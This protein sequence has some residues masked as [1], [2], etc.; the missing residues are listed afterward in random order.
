MDDAQVVTEVAE[1][2][3][4]GV[5]DAPQ[6]AERPSPP[7][8]ETV[9]D[10]GA[11]DRRDSIRQARETSAKA[12]E[13]RE[14]KAA[15]RAEPAKDRPEGRVRA[16]DGKFA[17]DKAPEAQVTAPSA[18]AVE[19]PK[20]AFP[21]AWASGTRKALYDAASPELRAELAGREQEQQAGVDK[22]RQETQRHT[23]IATEFDRVT[24]PYMATMR[25]MNLNPISVYQDF[26]NTA[27]ILNTG[28]PDQK[29]K[30][31]RD[32]AQ[33]YGVDLGSMQ[34][35]PGAYQ[36]PTITAFDR[37]LEAI[38]QGHLQRTQS[39]AHARMSDAERAVDAFAKETDPAGVPL[40]P[41]IETVAEDMMDRLPRLR[42]KNPGKPHGEILQMAY[43]AAVWGNA[44][45]RKETLAA[46]TKAQEDKRASDERERIARARHAAGSITGGPGVATSTPAQ[47]GKSRR[48]LISEGMS[49]HRV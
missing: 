8:H 47:Q 14:A 7:K 33:Q 30:I 21:K 19:P 45:T 5:P 13:A 39:E 36:D 10:R 34:A 27:Y 41:H 17:Q 37:R 22:M 25:S 38:E 20:A 2:P 24:Q 46:Q 11:R 49:S 35:D 48:A 18:A 31:I 32:T 42:D 4:G 3:A 23:Q 43:D 28:T 26:L 1:T 44:D 9:P 12:D 29:A 16:D 15:P 40:R 6:R